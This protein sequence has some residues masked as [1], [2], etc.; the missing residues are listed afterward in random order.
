MSGGSLSKRPHVAGFPGAYVSAGD[1]APLSPSAKTPTPSRIQKL[2]VQRS[3]SPP[4]CGGTNRQV[5]P[6]PWGSPDPGHSALNQHSWQTRAR[7]PPDSGF[8]GKVSPAPRSPSRA[9]AQ[10]TKPRC[11]G[12]PG[13]TPFISRGAH[14]PSQAPAASGGRGG[15]SRQTC[16]P[17]PQLSPCLL[18]TDTQLPEP[19]QPPVSPGKRPGRGRRSPR[20]GPR[21]PQTQPAHKLSHPEPGSATGPRDQQGTEP[22]HLPLRE[23]TR[24]VCVCG[25]M[26]RAGRGCSCQGA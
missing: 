17:E 4:S 25:E 12:P 24:R 22:P 18:I 6:G 19:Q 11:T 13:A 3:P 2:W 8:L 15:P 20:L 10:V 23:G 9:T 26:P 14:V 1:E 21:V 5:R 7:R 16:L